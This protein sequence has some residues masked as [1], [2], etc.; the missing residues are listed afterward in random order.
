MI[1]FQARR[2]S[3][4]RRLSAKRRAFLGFVL[5]SFLARWLLAAGSLGAASS[6]ADRTNSIPPEIIPPKV[7]REFRGAWVATVGNIDWPSKPGLPAEAQKNELIAIFNKATEIGLNAIVLQVRPACDAFFSSPMEPWSEYLSGKMGQAPNPPY[8]PLDF[9]VKEAHARGLELHAWFN[10][11]RAGHPTGKSSLSPKHIGR[12]HPKLVRVYGTHLWLDPG[13]SMVQE[14]VIRVIVDVVHRYDID[15]VHLDDYFYPYKEKNAKGEVIEFPDDASWRKYKSAGGRLSR[16]DWRRDNIN[17]FIKRLYLE[18]KTEKRWVK[19]GVSPFGIWQPGN[20]A[21]IKG[22]NA[23]EE[24]FADSRK[25]LTNGW[26]DYFSPQLYWS[27]QPKEQSY[28]LL[29]EWWKDQNKQGRFLWPADSAAKV[30][31]GW[32]CEEILRQVEI[33]RKYDAPGQLHWNM[34]ALMSNPEGL[35]EKLHKTRYQE[36][37]IVPGMDWYKPKPLGKPSL[38]IAKGPNDEEIITW[39]LRDKVALW[40]LQTK[41][42]DK[43]KTEILP[44]GTTE[45][46]IPA[47]GKLPDA[48]AVTAYDR[49]K[50]A[51]PVALLVP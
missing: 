15:G 18:I 37:A 21:E 7:M 20:P 39:K 26:V 43:W 49:Y 28:P 25:W 9:A 1:N 31:K 30:G 16:A 34:S 36:P 24:L 42:G 22:L 11:F 8:D 48:I 12:M 5:C 40:L 38:R 32:H 13:E 27:I 29:L 2:V 14:Y 45:K 4:Y 23:Y 17:K 51:S 47:K 35:A 6:A 44:E 33:S 10:P 50:L 41:E 19:F 3:V 46:R